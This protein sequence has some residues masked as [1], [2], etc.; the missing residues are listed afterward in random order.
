MTQSA[1]T[2]RGISYRAG[3]CSD[4]PVGQTLPLRSCGAQRVFG[5][6]LLE[7]NAAM[8]AKHMQTDA[9]QKLLQAPDLKPRE[10]FPY[11]RWMNNEGIPIHSAVAGVEDLTQLP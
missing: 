4:H 7:E 1:H 3:R 2:R 10:R 8:E 11:Y 6:I 5:C 9:K